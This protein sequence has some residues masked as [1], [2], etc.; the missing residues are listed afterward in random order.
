MDLP[1]YRAR[2]KASEAEQRSDFEN[3]PDGTSGTE[4]NETDSPEESAAPDTGKWTCILEGDSFPNVV[5]AAQRGLRLAAEGVVFKG[6]KPRPAN[7]FK[8]QVSKSLYNPYQQ[9]IVQPEPA[10]KLTKTGS[11]NKKKAKKKYAQRPKKASGAGDTVRTGKN[12]PSNESTDGAAA[13]EEDAEDA[14]AEASDGP[15]DAED[16][17]RLPIGIAPAKNASA[18]QLSADEAGN[19]IP[20]SLKQETGGGIEHASVIQDES[21]QH[22]DGN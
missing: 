22:T 3:D 9:S 10:P 12:S 16:G 21:E 4:A 17:D 13:P 15:S 11:K 18:E 7:L 14:G 19:V 20:S 1:E 8:G 2:Q 5:G 6:M